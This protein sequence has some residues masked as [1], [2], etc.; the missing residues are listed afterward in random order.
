MSGSQSNRRHP[1]GERVVKLTTNELRLL[2][3]PIMLNLA[4]APSAG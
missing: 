2:V 3:H 4:Y 1:V